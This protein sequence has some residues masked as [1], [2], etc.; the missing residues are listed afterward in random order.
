MSLSYTLP[1]GFRWITKS[2]DH[3]EFEHIASEKRGAV[4]HCE[5]AVTPDGEIQGVISYNC[6]KLLREV[7]KDQIWAESGR[8]MDTF[9]QRGG[10][11]DQRFR[12]L[13]NAAGGAA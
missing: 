5:R 4:S 12:E 6:A 3:L 9:R 1:A 10:D 7:A 2:R 13:L 11:V 8:N